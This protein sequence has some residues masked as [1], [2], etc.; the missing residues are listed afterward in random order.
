MKRP[1][2]TLV[3][4]LTVAWFAPQIASAA[5]PP[6]PWNKHCA[7]CHGPNGKGQTKAGRQAKVKD[8]T[9][10]A[11]QAT[12][13]DAAIV[14]SINEGLQRD[15]KEAMKSFKGQVSEAEIKELVAFVRSLKK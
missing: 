8:L 10:A 9:D 7:S 11:Y 2:V 13:D 4:A 12:F 15:G 6:A 14:K 3:A 5:A 1:L